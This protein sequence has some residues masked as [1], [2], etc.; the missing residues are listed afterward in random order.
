MV[1]KNECQIIACVP[2]HWH[3]KTNGCNSENQLGQKFC[4]LGTQLWGEENL[5]WRS[6]TAFDSVLIILRVLE[7]FN[8]SD[9]QSLLIYM[10]KYFKEDKK[11]VKGVTGIIQFEK[12]GVGVARRRHRINPPAEIVAVKWNA[13]QSKWQWTI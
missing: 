7:Q 2:W 3:S 6:G 1:D 9:S 10:N 13:Q 8:I 12:N 4:Q 5:T 11:Q